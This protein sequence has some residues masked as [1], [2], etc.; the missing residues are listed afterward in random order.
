MNDPYHPNHKVN[1]H[2]SGTDAGAIGVQAIGNT[3]LT[4]LC[5]KCKTILTEFKAL[6]RF[7]RTLNGEVWYECC[8]C[9]Y[10]FKF[11]KQNVSHVEKP[12]EYRMPV[13]PLARDLERKTGNESET[14]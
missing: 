7:D 9:D 1:G 13:K 5:P 14:D 10:E 8:E 2:M 11:C 4:L 3:G 12:L 6:S